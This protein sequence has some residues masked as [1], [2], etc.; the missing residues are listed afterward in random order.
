VDTVEKAV[1]NVSVATVA[2]S[3]PPSA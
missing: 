2:E 1:K 3:T